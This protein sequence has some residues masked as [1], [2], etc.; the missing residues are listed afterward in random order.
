VLLCSTRLQVN[1]AARFCH[2]AAR[3]GQV[4]LPKELICEVRLLLS[5][6]LF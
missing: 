6:L 2:A 5:L 1:R 3:G 4:L